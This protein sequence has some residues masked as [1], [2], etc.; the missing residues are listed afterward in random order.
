MNAAI[1]L[2]VLIHSP[3]VGPSTWRPV[4]EALANRGA[5][6]VV[7]ELHDDPGTAL[8]YWE[9]HA[10]AAARA[11]EVL[12]PERRL[13]LAGH[14]GAGPILPVIAQALARP[15]AAYLFVDAGLPRD[16]AT[17]LDL[18]RSEALAIA[19]PFRQMLLAGG[20]YPEWSDAELQ[21][22]VPDAERRQRLLAELRPRGRAF[23]EEP[24]PVFADWPDAPCA[25]LQ[26]SAAYTQPAEQAE[27]LAWPICK[28]E[29]SHFQMLVDPFA[30]A[31]ALLNLIGLIERCTGTAAP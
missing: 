2:F 19:E 17:R 21:P 5:E 28:L 27:Q 25:Y 12:S 10:N 8:P 1:P 9:Q 30:V 6:A 20:R 3:L 13:I 7:S 14:S 4:A 15:V 22:L 29:G 16:A 26:F 18:L 11:L 24:I 31:K 23:W